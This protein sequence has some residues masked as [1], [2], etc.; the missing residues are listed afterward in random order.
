MRTRIY[1]WFFWHLCYLVYKSRPGM[2]SQIVHC[3]GRMLL[4]YRFVVIS[5]PTGLVEISGAKEKHGYRADKHS[6]IPISLIIFLTILTSDSQF[7]HLAR[8]IVPW[9][10]MSI[11]YS[12]ARKRFRGF[13]EWMKWREVIRMEHILYCAVRVK[14]TR[15][16]FSACGD[17]CEYI[18][19][20]PK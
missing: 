10:S 8:W 15:S 12:T 11:Y 13:S 19:V 3:N 16:W 5:Q 20:L 4:L 14:C 1:I 6:I 7:E 2:N 17:T 18:D 9:S